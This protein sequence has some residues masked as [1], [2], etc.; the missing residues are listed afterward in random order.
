[1]ETLDV[2][3]LLSMLRFGAERIFSSAAGQPPSDAQ[4]DA[5]ISR[6]PHTGVQFMAAHSHSHMS[7]AQ[8]AG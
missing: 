1:M 6:N 7:E 2:R 3:E 8:P 5:I 4:L